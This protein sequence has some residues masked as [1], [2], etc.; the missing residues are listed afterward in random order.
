MSLAHTCRHCFAPLTE[1]FLDLGHAPLS[2]AYLDESGLQAPEVTYPLRLNVC[3]ECRLVQT[4]DY[5]SA[6]D[7]FRADYA[8]FSSTSSGWVAH[9]K[10]YTDM[11]V[12]RLQLGADSLVIE[13]AANDGYLLQ[14]MKM[15]GVPCLG[16]EPTTAT[17][18]A[19]R[20]KG[21]E[22]V[23]DFFGMPLAEKLVADGRSADLILGNNV[24]A[25]VPDINDFTRAIATTL[26]ADGIVTLEFPH[27]MRLVEHRQ[28]DTVYHEHFSY[29]SLLT[30]QQ[31][32]E[33]NGLRVVDVEEL[34][35]HGGSLRVYGCR[36]KAGHETSD[37]VAELLVEERTRGMDS[38]A[39]YEG[40]QAQ[41]EAVKDAA[42]RFLLDA[43]RDGKSVVGYGAA[44]KGNT[45]M[46][47]AG[48]RPDLMPRVHDAA[49]AKQDKFLPG[50]HIPIFAPSALEG[51]RPDYIVILPWNIADEVRAQ[52]SHLA[53]AGTLFVTF[54]PELKIL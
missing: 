30:V 16:V 11:I 33:A 35:T 41:S 22:I 29:L 8:Y 52:L 14:H 43:K 7:V 34:P 20:A 42:V 45:L 2:N 3:S 1:R 23:E 38:S 47:F 44:A 4:E 15:A 25:H 48:I 18:D 21:I 24:Y 36:T 32:F 26:K 46:N 49:P 50:S 17:A 10:R 39:F 28:F 9:A 5:T 54:V 51:T 53:E 31:I 40:F 37:K 27:L 12:E 19:A 6:A 13:L